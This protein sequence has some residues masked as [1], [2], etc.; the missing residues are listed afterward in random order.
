VYANEEF[1][2]TA[3]RESG[4]ARRD[5]FITTK[6]N[7]GEVL[8]AVNVSLRKVGLSLCQLRLWTQKN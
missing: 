5:L 7:G 1:V 2:G 8:D 4:L 6:Y 3:I